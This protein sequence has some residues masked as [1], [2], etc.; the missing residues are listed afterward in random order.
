MKINYSLKLHGENKNLCSNWDVIFRWD[1]ENRGIIN[2][3]LDAH[4]DDCQENL[5]FY[6]LINYLKGYAIYNMLLII[7]ACWEMLIV[8]TRLWESYRNLYLVQLQLKKE[9]FND[10][11]T[12][13]S[14]E[15]FIPNSINL[16]EE[17]D[18]KSKKS[19]ANSNENEN[20]INNK[21]INI[22]KLTEKNK[23]EVLRFSDKKKFFNLWLVLFCIGN[24]FQ[25]FTGLVNLI[26]PIFAEKNLILN[27]FSCMLAWF[28]IGYFL[29][30]QKKYSFFYTIIKHNSLKYFNL[31]LMYAVMFS[32]YIILG[33]C[34]F[35]S[36]YLFRSVSS[37]CIIFFS[38]I[39]SDTMLD[40]L[41][42]MAEK[43][44][45]FTVLVA[46]M[47]FLSFY[48]FCL[49]I[50]ISITEDTFGDIK[51]KDNYSWLNKNKQFGLKDYIINH[52]SNPKSP[53]D[54]HA[55]QEENTLA[56]NK[57]L[58]C[59]L[60]IHA[61]LARENALDKKIEKFL[62]KEDYNLK[63]DFF[64]NDEIEFDLIIRKKLKKIKKTFLSKNMLKNIVNLDMENDP[65]QVNLKLGKT[66]WKN[67]K[68][69]NYYEYLELIFKCIIDH[70]H[71]V[72][73]AV[74]TD[75][76]YMK[77]LITKDA[78]DVISM[79]MTSIDRILLTIA[80]IKKID[81]INLKRTNTA[82]NIVLSIGY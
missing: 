5:F 26:F 49:R 24:I 65:M 71:K 29:D 76:T 69:G 50:L 10:F 30:Y 62:I 17:A 40:A 70:L 58:V 46:F 32:V 67:K 22:K 60:F 56:E 21:F 34:F 48:M 6:L 20:I 12:S 35:S 41:S 15:P 38:L 80:R 61:L 45:Y 9:A 7:F 64:L 66:D 2:H 19:Y 59:D 27:S 42:Q 1:V 73:K 8:L 25:I 57:Y 43:S 77:N 3:K 74:F 81:R 53:D 37:T 28:G 44:P 33:L 23:W 72:G 82:G 4:V 54:E 63:K 52:I 11:S 31:L 39:F 78:D 75:K 14:N 18:F 79:V 68:L 51:M 16:P 55:E 13:P 36:L 47:Y